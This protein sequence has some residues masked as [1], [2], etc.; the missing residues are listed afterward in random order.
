MLLSQAA[1]AQHSYAAENG[2]TNADRKASRRAPNYK[3]GRCGLPK[4]GHTCLYRWDK[5]PRPQTALAGV[6]YTAAHAPVAAAPV[7]AVY[8]KPRPLV[9]AAPANV[10]VTAALAPSAGHA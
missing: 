1:H 9:T 5:Q 6:P 2:L 8:E 4:R 3:C 10:V 7:A